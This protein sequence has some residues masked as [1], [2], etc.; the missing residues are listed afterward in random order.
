MRLPAQLLHLP[1]GLMIASSFAADAA[2]REFG[3]NQYVERI[4]GGLPVIIGAPHGGTLKPAGIPS[5]TAGVVAQDSHTQELARMI[6]EEMERQFGAAPHLIVCRLHRLKAD[7]NREIKEAAQGNAEAERAFREFHAFIAKSRAEAER[8]FG[9]GLY[10]D[11]HGHRHEDALVEIGALVPAAK[12]NLTN[13]KL[14]A[15]GLVS[16]MSSIRE[17]DARSP[18]PFSQLLRGPKSLGGLL[19]AR[20]FPSV[21][22][23]GHP[24]PGLKPYFNGAYNIETHGSRS[25]G[26]VSA[27]QIECPFAGVRDKAENRRRFA[28]ALSESLGEY[29][30]AHFGFSLTAKARL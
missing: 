4:A 28:K 18:Q 7:C 13:A 29:F 3:T 17:L 9:C 12:L 21:P 27:V 24:S 11:L 8:R 1:F 26:T 6:R 30:K 15:G 10:I 20:G 23:P 2:K 25:G 22:S 19:E 5:R 14:D 16:R